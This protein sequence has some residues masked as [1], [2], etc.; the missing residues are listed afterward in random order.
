MAVNT[1]QRD[2]D[3]ARIIDD[4]ERR[5]A[6]LERQALRD[7]VSAS[8]WQ[9]TPGG[10]DTGWQDIVIWQAG[11]TPLGGANTPQA[12][13]FGPMVMLRGRANTAGLSGTTTFGTLPS[14]FTFFPD[15]ITELGQGTPS[16]AYVARYFLTAA[17]VLSAQGWV[18]GA[19]LTI[20]GTYGVT[21]P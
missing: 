11:V 16:T 8:I 15:G 5:I 13:R 12:R 7:P 3:I 1:V 4:Y 20:G 9:N 10:F 19:V 17:G 2:Y 21:A 6:F 18:N 14:G